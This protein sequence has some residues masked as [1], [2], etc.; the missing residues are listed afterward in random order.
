MLSGK[1][2]IEDGIMYKHTEN[3]SCHTHSQ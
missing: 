2:D 1:E 3:H